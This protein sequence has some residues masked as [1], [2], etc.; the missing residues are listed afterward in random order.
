MAAQQVIFT[1]QKELILL[2]KTGTGREPRNFLSDQ[3]QHISFSYVRS[4]LL[5]LL[6]GKRWQRRI[7]IVAKGIRVFFDE[8]DH[9][10]YFDSYIE[11][12]R[13]FCKRN[14]V[15]LEDFPEMTA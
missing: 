9:K 5:R 4:G 1:D 14:Y 11:N 3:I 7:T 6:L 8:S 2:L 12:L 15:T 10:Q 13:D